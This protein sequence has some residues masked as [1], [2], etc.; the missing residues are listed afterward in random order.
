M[1]TLSWLV[2]FGFIKKH[3]AKACSYVFTRHVCIFS[4]ASSW[5]FRYSIRF[6]ASCLFLLTA[7]KLSVFG[8]F[9]V[10]IFSHL[11]WRRKDMEYSVQMRENADQ[12][13]SEYRHFSRSEFAGAYLSSSGFWQWTIQRRIQNP[14]KQLRW[15]FFR[16]QL[17]VFNM[18]PINC[19]D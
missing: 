7:W 3:V 2:C 1:T 8:V 4:R 5:L 13:N 18:T 17:R 9:L 11:D 19:T 15:S 6:I 14:F 16:K 12:K 10:R